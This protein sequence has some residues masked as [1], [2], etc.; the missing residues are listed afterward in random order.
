MI[1]WWV[2]VKS[3]ETQRRVYRSYLVLSRWNGIVSVKQI[4]IGR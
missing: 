1:D 3:K 4:Y 2:L